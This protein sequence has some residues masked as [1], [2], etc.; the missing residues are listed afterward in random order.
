MDE[1]TRVEVVESFEDLASED[2][3]QL[4]VEVIERLDDFLDWSATYV[5]I[6]NL[7]HVIV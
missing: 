4:L 2:S 1:I 3:D 6:D 7:D 5:V